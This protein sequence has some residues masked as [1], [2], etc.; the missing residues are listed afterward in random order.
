MP[1]TLI[2][3]ELSADEWIISC[4]PLFDQYGYEEFSN[5]TYPS[6]EACQTR[7]DAL[8]TALPDLLDVAARVVDCWEGGDL[9]EAVR[10]LAQVLR[11]AW[12]SE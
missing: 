2:P 3:Y 11:T 4:P 9:A 7:I 8:N 5:R 6:R 1:N 10:D 12:R